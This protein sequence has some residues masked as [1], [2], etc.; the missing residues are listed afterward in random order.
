MNNDRTEKGLPVNCYGD[1]N[2]NL[3]NKGSK[4]TTPR[5]HFMCNYNMTSNID[6][7]TIMEPTWQR[8][9]QV[10]SVPIPQNG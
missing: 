10:E 4:T 2:D 1:F 3:H 8:A 6:Y 9:K 7:H 5:L